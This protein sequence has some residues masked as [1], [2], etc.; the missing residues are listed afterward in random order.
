MNSTLS[1]KKCK[2]YGLQL[3]SGVSLIIYESAERWNT[4]THLAS[5]VSPMRRELKKL[6]ARNLY[7]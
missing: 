1:K 3:A 4:S 7:F 2:L 5:G 6:G